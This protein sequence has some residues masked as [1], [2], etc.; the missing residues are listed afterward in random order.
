[1]SYRIFV[2]STREDLES[3]RKAVIEA[4][5]DAG[6]RIDPM[7]NWGADERHP[8]TFCQDKIT[9]SDLVILIV[10]YRRGFIP[11]PDGID[12]SITQLEH[13]CADENKIDVLPFLLKEDQPWLG[14]FDNLN[15]NH[16]DE[17]LVKWRNE[18]LKDHGCSLFTNKPSTLVTSVLANVQRW[19][20]RH[21]NKSD[22]AI[23]TIVPKPFIKDIKPLPL[24]NPTNS[25]FGRE[26]EME[27][28]TKKLTA[29][30]TGVVTLIGPSGIGK[31]RLVIEV[32]N[33]FDDKLFDNIAFCRLSDITTQ[34]GLV[35][36]IG[37]GIGLKSLISSDAI[38]Q[39][40]NALESLGNILLILDN[41]EHVV[42]IVKSMIEHIR[43][44]NPNVCFLTSSQKV[45]DVYGEVLV[46]LQ[47]LKLPQ[48]NEDPMQSPTVK[49]FLDRVR[50]INS[51]MTISNDGLQKI[52][53]IC[54]NL[55][56]EPSLIETASGLMFMHSIESLWEKYFSDNQ[57]SMLNVS[58]NSI[59]TTNCMSQF[60][61]QKRNFELLPQEYQQALL[62]LSVFR[63]GMSYEAIEYVLEEQSI[64]I[65]G[66]IAG[67]IKSSNLRTEECQGAI[68]YK[69]Y[70][71]SIHSFCKKYCACH[72]NMKWPPK[73]AAERWAT[74]LQSYGN[75][76]RKRASSSQQKD[77]LD[78]LQLER[79]N[80]IAS[81]KWAIDHRKLKLAFDL[82]LTCDKI[83]EARGPWEL[84]VHLL[85][86]LLE[87][88]DPNEE[89]YYQV[90]LSLSKA[91]WNLGDLT[92]SVTLID[93]AMNTKPSNLH[94]S[95]DIWAEFL[96]WYA[97]VIQD[98]Q[99]Y[100][101]SQNKFLEA[102]NFIKKH[103]PNS[104][105][106]IECKAL[107]GSTLSRAGFL[108]A[109]IEYLQEAKNLITTTTVPPS[110]IARVH[111]RL[112]LG[113]WRS[114]FTKESL[115]HH[116]FCLSIYTELN[117][118]KWIAGV[119]TNQALALID[120]EEYEEALK[121]CKRARKLHLSV[122]NKSWATVNLGTYG[123]ILACTQEYNDAIIVL[124]EAIQAATK[125]NYR[126]D[127]SMHQGNLGWVY[128]Q[129]NSFDKAKEYLQDAVKISRELKC[130]FTLRHFGNL[131]QL[132]YA[133]WKTQI[134]EP[135]DE[136]ILEADELVV[137]FEI[138][139]SQCLPVI[140][141]FCLFEE[142]KQDIQKNSERKP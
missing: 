80:F 102:L 112:G 19:A 9:K 129:L 67:L 140:K 136:I 114:G 115:K 91:K 5:R 27:E 66:V 96:L 84:R 133:K 32:C 56:G 59:F 137:R 7:E 55:G 113:L 119:L 43:V 8:V 53:D 12:K 31:T 95:N 44:Q 36:A 1:M 26:Q 69:I 37:Q 30:K 22:S 14:K 11:D 108:E 107:L 38:E 141:N 127:V 25:F 46:L 104:L 65:E 90:I 20:E 131:V 126:E 54:H 130:A 120:L 97:S 18:L 121:L 87:I 74:W 49:L 68:R 10:A 79:E 28:I 57:S 33:R 106:M 93:T 78:Q 135:N 132:L 110:S 4:L 23:E 98:T 142:I 39:V 24:P 35:N 60:E 64:H 116:E 125:I 94:I 72:P 29:Q 138:N 89:Y 3:H 40:I 123:K 117:D 101:E 92:G 73:Q 58:T 100:D 75:R 62:Y 70:T 6:H 13:Q 52:V 128:N 50:S 42:G 83:M 77:A 82:T 17:E 34:A 118:Q 103:L 88:C 63:N 122:G 61:K 109:G 134:I 71:Q 76:H 124:K 111:N 139:T 21:R 51:Q 47:P 15:T 41:C 99:G 81:S 105:I 45:I 86:K 2:A 85:E 48:K 16:P